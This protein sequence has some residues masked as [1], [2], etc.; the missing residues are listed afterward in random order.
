MRLRS[1]LALRVW[2]ETGGAAGAATGALEGPGPGPGPGGVAGGH[3]S[4][5]TFGFH[6]KRAT[7][8]SLR[9]WSR[10]YRT[11]LPPINKF[12]VPP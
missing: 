4:H 5:T 6:L 2:V 9:L 8:H 7:R 12:A 11:L 10:S 3:G 1:P